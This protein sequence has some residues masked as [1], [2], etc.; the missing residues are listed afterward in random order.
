MVRTS[1]QTSRLTSASRVRR[2]NFTY[3]PLDGQDFTDLEKTF[4]K[5]L[6]THSD[7]RNAHSVRYFQ[8]QTERAPNPAEGRSGLHYQGFIAWTRKQRPLS[9]RFKGNTPS[10]FYKRTS[11]WPADYQEAS[12]KY[13]TKVRTRVSDGAHGKGGSLPRDC[14]DTVQDV[15]DDIADRKPLEVILKDHPITAF[16]H[17]SKI[18]MSY[19][20]GI[21]NRTRAD[22]YI[23]VG[24]PGTGKT[25][26]AKGW[27]QPEGVTGDFYESPQMDNDRWDLFAYQ[28]QNRF[29]INEFGSHF[30]K[31]NRLLTLFD[32]ESSF[33]LG[34]KHDNFMLKSNILILTMNKD[35]T[36]WYR[37]REGTK[38]AL[39]RRM[40]QYCKIYDFALTCTCPEPTA[41]TCGHHHTMTLRTY[42]HRFNVRTGQGGF[43]FGSRA[44]QQVSGT[45]FDIS[46]SPPDIDFSHISIP[47]VL[48]EDDLDET[49]LDREDIVTFL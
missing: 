42:E 15:I 32:A 41:C 40:D 11:W 22:I 18:V 9:L 25:R 48:D 6:C 4:F 34:K 31:Y 2:A 20:D 30:M 21:P 7:K 47:S 36:E 33:Q 46:P 26:T 1:R 29:I 38:L 35:P 45:G 23:F 27:M 16:H 28:G 3:W 13:S 17:R 24:P 39:Q 10:F 5:D 37:M 19:M 49:G 14:E 12:L 44:D 8:Y 43:Q